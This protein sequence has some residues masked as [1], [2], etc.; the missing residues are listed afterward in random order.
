MNLNILIKKL[1]ENVLRLYQEPK[2][3]FTKVLS[4][5]QCVRLIP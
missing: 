1:L 4:Q 3:E 2:N 5:K